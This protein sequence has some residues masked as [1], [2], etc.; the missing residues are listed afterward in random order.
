M[1]QEQKKTAVESKSSTAK[2]DDKKTAAA[3]TDSK[4]EPEKTSAKTSSG[5]T[6]SKSSNQ[7]DK[8]TEKLADSLASAA[9]K[10]C[11]T[12]SDSKQAKPEVEAPRRSAAPA[13]ER[14]AANDDLPSIGGLIYALQQRPSRTPFYVA[15]GAS[16][17][18]VFLCLGAA[19]F[20]FNERLSGLSSGGDMLRDPAALTLGAT[21]FVPVVLFW[22]LALLIWRAQELRLMASAMTEVAVRLAEPD[23]MAAQSVASLGQ[24]IRRQ[25]AAMNDAISRALGRA[26]ELEALVHNEVSALERSYSENELRI[27]GLIDELASERDALSN[28]SERVMETLRGVGAQV[29]KDVSEAGDQA[30]KSL[31]SATST[32]ANS[33]SAR[34]S[35][36]TEAI[37]AAGTAVDNKMAERGNAITQQLSTQGDSVTKMLDNA[38]NNVSAALTAAT[39]KVTDVVDV[40]SNQLV[41]SLSAIGN[42]LVQDIPGL[43]DRL[44]G[45]QKR[46]S[47]I[48]SGASQ[49]FTALEAA[50][51]ERTTQLDGTLKNRTEELKATLADRIRALDSTVQEQTKS[52]ESMVQNQAVSIETLVG[53]QAKSIAGTVGKLESTVQSQSASIENAVTSQSQAIETAVSNQAKSIEGTVGKLQAAVQNQAKAIKDTLTGQ[54]QAMEN[55]V[56]EQAASLAS[57][58]QQQAKAIESTM[59]KNSMTIS[60][61]FAEGTDAV[62]KTTEYIVDQ[63]DQANNNMNVQMESLRSVSG[64]LLKQVHGLTERFETQGQAIMSASQALDSSNAQIDSILERRHAEI[65]S[66]LDTVSTKAQALD[67]MM[68]SYSGIIEGS[69][70]QVEERAK[71][72]TASLAQETTA[73]ADSTIQEI[74]RLRSSARQHTEQAVQELTGGFQSITSEVADQL[75]TLTSRFGETTREIRQTASSTAGEIEETRQE[76]TRRMQGLPEATRQSQEAVRK[77]V[78]DQLKALGTLSALSTG[79]GAP[80]PPTPPQSPQQA[81]PPAAGYGGGANEGASQ[82]A[83]DIASVTANLASQLG[84]ATNTPPPQ[85]PAQQTLPPETPAASAS[86]G[87]GVSMRAQPPQAQDDRWSV[88]DLLARASGPDMSSQSSASQASAGIELRLND[89][90]SAIDQNTASAVWQRFRRGERDIFSRQLYT[91]QGQ[92]TFDE[93]TG[94]YQRDAAFR[95]T[96]DRYIGDFERLLSD[97]ERKGQNG[98]A[99]DNYLVSETGR[100]YLMLAHA[101]GRLQ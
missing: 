48:I 23:K 56:A 12:G 27:R 30:T 71:Q 59:A 21:L 3:K 8:L 31:A 95:A 53:N 67:Q 41:N 88:G 1:A 32:L 26:G 83:D 40:K 18:W 90:A 61:V 99:I 35:K 54:T 65:A 101:S 50:L 60:Q 17:A 63:S 38:G 11:S 85:Q 37:S 97:A 93:I 91:S 100:V 89:I 70:V 81:L 84:S 68:R 20:L 82:S 76:L 22:F 55:S 43:L 72:I 66:L 25:V 46:L 58:I 52:L 47:N 33:L 57:N 44:D 42:Q 87:L 75:G 73:Q 28:N 62:R 51:A 96:V 94:R 69:L 98:Q 10:E 49:N 29:S 78:S 6:D 19:L 2:R 24:T 86:T 92:A 45:E 64:Q 9:P 5:K 13:R 16:I 80:P 36:I 34:G 15:F 74:E 77:A 39:K 4:K 7:T 14:I 79:A